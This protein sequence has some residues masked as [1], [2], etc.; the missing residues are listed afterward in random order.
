[1]NNH[2]V[3]DYETMANCFVSVFTHYKTDETKIFVIHEEIND[4]KE[5]IIF[6][7]TN[8]SNKE[9]HISYN[10]L[11]FDAQITEYMLE[12]KDTWE[13]FSAKEITHEVYKLAQHVIGKQSSREWLDYYEYNMQIPQLDVYKLNHWD[14][15]AKRS[16]LKWIQFSMRW[17]NLQD[18]PIHHGDFIYDKKDLD[19]IIN[20][21][22]NDVKST[23]EIF[24]RSIDLVKLR[25]SLT[26][27][28]KINLYN[29]SEPKISKELFLHFLTKKT[30][31]KKNDLKYANTI[32]ESIIV[33]DL[34]LPY[35][36]FNNNELIK[37][38]EKFKSKII[39]PLKTKRGFTAS[40][41]FHGVKTDFG[42]GGIH[43]ARVAGIYKSNEDMIIMSSDVTSFYPNLAIRNKWSP[44]HLPKEEFCEQYE[45][46][47]N[48]RVKIPKT[49]ILNYVYKLILNSTYG[50]SNDKYSFLYDPQFTMQ[51]TINGQLSLLMLYE[52]IMDEIPGSI[53]L[54]QNTDGLE[55]LIPKK[56]KG[57]YLEICKEWENIT[58]LNLEH[59]VYR[60]LILADVNNYIA[61][62]D[63]KKVER[64]EYNK[65]KENC[66]NLLKQENGNFYYSKTKCKGRFEFQNLPLH[67]NPSSLI[68]SK[69]LYHY[70]LNDVTPEKYLENNKNIFDYCIGKKIKGNWK[71][72]KRWIKKG[73]YTVEDLQKTIRYYASNKG[74]KIIKIN[75]G[76][77][78]EIQTEAGKWLLTI[79]NVYEKKEWSKYNID[80][81]YYLNSIYTEIEN[82]AGPKTKQ[83]KLF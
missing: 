50:L 7:E 1:M 73:Q 63:W 44:A 70:F 64:N 69:A 38:L 22:I 79:F 31:L 80:D 46:F 14:N 72:E 5:F 11:G 8:I 78:R 57:K 10:G 18:M 17:K 67:K 32:R 13:E 40:V 30:G 3:M 65:L 39:D 54:M 34:I 61:V 23:K 43:G 28:Y 51:I 20:Y 24:N 25:K 81:K 49:N 21:C 19:M 56:H 74:C 60:Q 55:T 76:D 53:P 9:R 47:F 75:K 6:L 41:K 62:H 59:D 42:L 2:W 15:A 66:H 58:S 35:I 12:A 45:W 29:A 48:E 77:A 33:K 83:I 71:F 16:S 36:K 27:Q 52:M 37:L 4:F 82:V 68:V 26:N